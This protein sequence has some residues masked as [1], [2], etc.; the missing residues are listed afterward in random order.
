MTSNLSTGILFDYNHTDAKTDS[1]GSKTTVNTYSPGAYAT[2]SDHGFYVNGLFTFGYSQYSNTRNISF[3]NAVATSSPTGNQYVTN[4]DL[5]YDFHPG[6]AWT[7][8]PSLGLTYT[9]LNI[10]SIQE[11][12]APGE[13][14]AIH[15]QNNGDDL[16]SEFGGHL[17]YQTHAGNVLL[18]PDLTVLWQHEYLNLDGNSMTSNFSDFGSSSFTTATTAPSANSA[19]IECGVTA[20]LD[21]SMAFY[22][23]YM[24]DVGA[25]N[26]FAQSVVGGFKARF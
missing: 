10:S 26:Y 20:T 17:L 6:Q 7:I 8:G 1:N 25:T 15:S 21:N 16:R 13:D 22:L 11:T 23:D 2:Y 14:L 9:H 4:L 24:A 18:A 5:G 19:L 3:A 12:G